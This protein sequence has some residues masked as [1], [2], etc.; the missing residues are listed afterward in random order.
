[1]NYLVSQDSDILDLANPNNPDRT[2]L[3]SH[4]PRLQI[5]DPVSFLAEMRRKVETR[6]Q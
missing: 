5:L 3:R 2:R 4:A 6:G 1:V